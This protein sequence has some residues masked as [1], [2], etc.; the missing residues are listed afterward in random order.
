MQLVE[1]DYYTLQDIA[2]RL[3]VSY[4]TVYRWVRAGK[5]PAYKFGQDWRVKESDLREFVEAHRAAPD[6]S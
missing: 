1:E 5:L 6:E 3:K 4:R 2:D